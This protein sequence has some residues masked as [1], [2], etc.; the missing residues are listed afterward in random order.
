MKPS[1]EK[2]REINRRKNTGEIMPWIPP[3]TKNYWECPVCLRRGTKEFGFRKHYAT[4]SE[5]EIKEWATQ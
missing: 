3:G 2:Q 1:I 5:E 4:H